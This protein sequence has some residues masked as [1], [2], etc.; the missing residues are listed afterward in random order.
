[1]K[2]LDDGIDDERFRKEF[3]SFGIIIS[4]K[5]KR[6][7]FFFFLRFGKNLCGCMY[8]NFTL[9]YLLECFYDL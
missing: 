9:I 2:N 6:M 4:V 3:F 5:V 8:R 1:M 7:M